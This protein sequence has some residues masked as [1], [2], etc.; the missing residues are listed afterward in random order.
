MSGQ[1]LRKI[2][3]RKCHIRR[4]N[5]NNDMDIEANTN[6]RISINSWGQAKNIYD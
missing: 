2:T 5:L 1:N 6:V 4:K 3:E